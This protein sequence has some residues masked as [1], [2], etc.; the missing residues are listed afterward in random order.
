MFGIFDWLPA[1]PYRGQWQVVAIILMAL[2]VYFY[3]LGP[4]RHRHR[5]GP[6]AP[7]WRVGCA[8]AAAFAVYLSEGTVLHTLSEQYLFSAHMLQHSLL[9]LVTAPCIVMALPDWLVRYA[10]RFPGVAPVARFLTRPLIAY[11]AYN[12]VY[13][14]WHFPI[15]Y[16][17]PLQLHWLHLIQHITMAGTAVLMWWPLLSPSSDLPRLSYGGQLV[18]AFLMVV[19]QLP[20]FAPITFAH[21]PIYG[22]YADAPRVWVIGPLEDQQWAGIIMKLTSML[23][24]LTVVGISFFRW[25]KEEGGAAM[26]AAGRR[27]RQVPDHASP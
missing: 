7:R 18:Y 9:I 20:L 5:L 11:L 19:A 17:A 23:V 10:L 6:P 26:H 16:Q 12:V 3:C 22:F 25:A 21:A 1:A 4:L 2:G 14:A 24:L 15:F 27:S 8:L 13:A